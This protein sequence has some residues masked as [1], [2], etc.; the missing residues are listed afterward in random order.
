VAAIFAG[1]NR[2]G[3]GSVW[4]VRWTGQSRVVSQEVTGLRS[5]FAALKTAEQR[6]ASS[7]D[8]VSSISAGDDGACLAARLAGVAMLALVCRE[9]GPRA[10]DTVLVRARAAPSDC[11]GP[12]GRGHWVLRG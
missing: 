8:E 11:P 4:S 6:F 7:K 3:H 2:I 12:R 1:G 10:A 5:N 9:G